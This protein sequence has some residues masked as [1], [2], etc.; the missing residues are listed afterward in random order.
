VQSSATFRREEEGF[1]DS[2]G[3]TLLSAVPELGEN[4]VLVSLNFNLVCDDIIIVVVCI[5]IISQR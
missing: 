5:N 2:H 3:G 1:V 4:V